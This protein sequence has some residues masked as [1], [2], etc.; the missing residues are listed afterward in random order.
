[1]ILKGPKPEDGGDA[2]AE[3]IHDVKNQDLW[4]DIMAP[5]KKIQNIILL[6]PRRE[7]TRLSCFAKEFVLPD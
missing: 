6:N 4:K 3:K 2:S 1:M 7:V 5:D